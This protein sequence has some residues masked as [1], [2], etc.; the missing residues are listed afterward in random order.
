MGQYRQRHDHYPDEENKRNCPGAA[1]RQREK[2]FARKKKQGQGLRNWPAKQFDSRAESLGRKRRTEK[3]LALSHE[4]S[5][6][7]DV[8]T[9]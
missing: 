5:H 6:V 8:G 2:V 3:E 1:I 4:S 9:C 7:R